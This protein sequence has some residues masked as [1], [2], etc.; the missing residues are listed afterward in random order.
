MTLAE[1]YLLKRIYSGVLPTFQTVTRKISAIKRFADFETLP[2]IRHFT[3]DRTNREYKGPSETIGYVSSFSF[4][5]LSCVM[6]KR[7]NVVV[8]YYYR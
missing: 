7:G 1:D 4:R 3:G 2:R 5:R 6:K 8:V